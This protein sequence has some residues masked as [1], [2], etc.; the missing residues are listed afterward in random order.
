MDRSP[1]APGA[2]RD[3][4]EYWQ[5]MLVVAVAIALF[6]GAFALVAFVRRGR[7]TEADDRLDDMA[8]RANDFVNRHGGF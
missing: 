1:R 4:V 7:R 5:G 3:G 8:M 6:F 2:Y